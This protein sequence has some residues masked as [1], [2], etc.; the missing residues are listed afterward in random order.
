MFA[1]MLK[2]L[3]AVSLFYSRETAATPAPLITLTLLLPF[4]GAGMVEAAN[5]WGL[6]VAALSLTVA[7]AHWMFRW[8]TSRLPD[9]SGSPCRPRRVITTRPAP[10]TPTA[11]T[12]SREPREGNHTHHFRGRE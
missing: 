8:I 10:Y 12:G 9:T 2:A 7:P 1:T 5:D 6:A 11:V 4:L 3:R